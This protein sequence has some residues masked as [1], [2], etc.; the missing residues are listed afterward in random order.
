ME[1]SLP[2]SG[3]QGIMELTIQAVEIPVDCVSSALRSK[4]SG[5]ETSHGFL[6]LGIGAVAASSLSCH[7]SAGNGCAQ[8]AGLGGA[9]YFHFPAYNIS[10]NLHQQLILF[11]NTTAVDYFIYP[12]TVFLKAINNYQRQLDTRRKGPV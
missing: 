12:H 2:A 8:G 6:G 9:G 3:A 10:I 11:S 7:H 4:D 1:I 5:L